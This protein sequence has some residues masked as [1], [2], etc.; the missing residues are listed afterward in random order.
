[1]CN[2]FAFRATDPVDMRA[3][4]DPIGPDNDAAILESARRCDLIVCAWG[5]H[6]SYLDRAKAV[7]GML[8][9]VGA[10]L[11]VLKITGDGHPGHPLYL[12]KPLL[13]TLW[14]GHIP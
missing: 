7:S 5:N 11:R 6:G 1:M 3:A 9:A 4:A 8:R 14:D 10:E 2:I 12:K 13:P